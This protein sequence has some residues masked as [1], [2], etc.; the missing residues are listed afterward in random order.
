MGR[1]NV[2]IVL[3]TIYTPIYFPGL[4][5]IILSVLSNSAADEGDLEGA[6]VKGKISLGLSLAGIAITVISIIIV[7][8]VVVV[9]VDDA[10]DDATNWYNNNS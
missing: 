10:V 3:V 2:L 8:V 1:A 4:V 6:R 7:I 9:M 5:A